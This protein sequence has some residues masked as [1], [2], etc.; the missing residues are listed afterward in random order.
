MSL[1]FFVALIGPP[2]ETAVSGQPVAGCA[3]H[4][5]S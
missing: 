3:V 1:C 2:L 5:R 4:S